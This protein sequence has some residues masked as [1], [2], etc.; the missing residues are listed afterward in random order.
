MKIDENGHSDRNT[1]YEIKRQKVTKQKLGC[2]FIRIDPDIFKA[3]N[4][5]FRHFKQSS[6]QSTKKILIDRIS[7][8][9]LKLELKSH[10]T[11][12]LK[13]MKYILLKN[14]APL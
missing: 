3:I 11:I 2:E 8:I 9:L 1:G 13:V 14:I 10:N 4:Q 7:T 12:K 6:N 5:I